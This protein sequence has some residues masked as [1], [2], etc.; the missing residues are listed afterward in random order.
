[1]GIGHFI[2]AVVK[3]CWHCLTGEGKDKNFTVSYVSVKMMS[4]SEGRVTGSTNRTQSFKMR[5]VPVPSTIGS[6]AKNEFTS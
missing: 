6:T 4:V 2:I 5:Q 3:L 1:M